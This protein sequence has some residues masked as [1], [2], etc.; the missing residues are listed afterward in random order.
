MAKFKR[1]VAEPLLHFFLIG[2]CIF[3]V[4]G[5]ETVPVEEPQVIE[6]T[7][8]RLDKLRRRW[9]N[10]HRR[11]P[12]E[13]E[14]DAEVADYVREEILY[15]EALRL[16]LDEGDSTIRHQLNQKLLFL[17]EN[18]QPAREPSRAELQ[19]QLVSH[20]EEFAVGGHARFT[21]IYVSPGKR[22]AGAAAHASDIL[23]KLTVEQLG[24]TPE[25]LSDAFPMEPHQELPRTEI[26]KLFGRAFERQLMQAPTGQ[27]TGP[28]ES[29]Y[30]LHIVYVE[31]AY[32]GEL[33]P[34]ADV[35]D[36]VR[37]SWQ[38]A[39]RDRHLEDFYRRLRGQYRVQ[40]AGADAA[41]AGSL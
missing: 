32:G 8:A 24:L 13:S 36:A 1:L 31:D 38:R 40:L 3:A 7:D 33:P 34:L 4:A 41:V 30:G 2:A 14:L 16:G 12:T 25:E 37:R 21:H 10:E 39:R 15:R 29:H 9:E 27:W 20:P 22:G 6:I 5:Q 18:R 23:R 28:I 35:E 19:E 11:P 26:G 17:A